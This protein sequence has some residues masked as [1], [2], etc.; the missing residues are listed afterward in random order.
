MSHDNDVTSIGV[1]DQEHFLMVS[2]KVAESYDMASTMC[3]EVSRPMAPAQGTVPGAQ[4]A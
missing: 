3:E 1:R 2:V 4:P